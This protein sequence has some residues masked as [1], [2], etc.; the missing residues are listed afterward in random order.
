V[1][2]DEII[3]LSLQKHETNDVQEQVEQFSSAARMERI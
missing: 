2:V 3:V 1:K